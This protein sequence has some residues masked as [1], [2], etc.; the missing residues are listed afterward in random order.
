LKKQTAGIGGTDDNF[1]MPPQRKMGTK[2]FSRDE[3]LR[4]Y[5]TNTSYSRK[6]SN[7]N[8]SEYSVDKS[9]T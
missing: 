4:K 6:P 3:S 8:K 2:V 9:I 7:I 1:L 5:G